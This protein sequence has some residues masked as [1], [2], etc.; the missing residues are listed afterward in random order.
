MLM[1]LSLVAL[2]TLAFASP[3]QARMTL[4]YQSDTQVTNAPDQTT[5]FMANQANGRAMRLMVQEDKWSYM[6]DAYL[7]AVRAAKS[8]GLFVMVSMYRWRGLTG[9]ERPGVTPSEWASF[10]RVAAAKLAPYVDAWSVMNEP[11]HPAFAPAVST[12][13]C[14]LVQGTHIDTRTV[15]L[16]NG[17]LKIVRYKFAKRGQWRHGRRWHK[18]HRY[19]RAA[20]HWHGQRYKRIVRK[21]AQAK[22]TTI[23]VSTPYAYSQ[24]SSTALGA[25]YR[26]VYDAS[27]RELRRID[28]TATLVFGDT[29]GNGIAG[30][31]MAAALAGHPDADVL[32]VHYAGANTEAANLARAHGLAPW[33]TEWGYKPVDQARLGPGLNTLNSN[34]YARV[35]VYTLYSD[36]GH[37]WDTGLIDGTT[38]QP[39]AGFASARAW[40]L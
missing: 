5:A 28:P 19:V 8:H 26:A 16:P 23:Q 30:G 6:S 3:A 25:A 12:S 18:R 38:G 9:S 11:N 34:G 20:K 24:C 39:R 27:A 35:F 32:G 13:A 4:G 21:V 14:T 10:T 15:I 33:A 37:W 2:A 1:R 36:P 7:S 40:N 29:A 22:S 17:M 31:F